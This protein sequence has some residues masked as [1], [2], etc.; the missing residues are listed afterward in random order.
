MQQLDYIILNIYACP[1]GWAAQSVEHAGK[2]WCWREASERKEMQEVKR[3][4]QNRHSE[5]THFPFFW[6]FCPEFISAV[7]PFHTDLFHISF[8][9][10]PFHFTVYTWAFF[11]HQRGTRI[12]KVVN[13]SARCFTV[14]CLRRS[15]P[16]VSGGKSLV[17]SRVAHVV[18]AAICQQSQPRLSAQLTPEFT[19]L[20]LNTEIGLLCI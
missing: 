15:V 11:S 7:K 8:Q 19:F 10:L 13:N 16:F 3:G 5:K 17:M 12:R 1:Q 14:S 2:R 6:N 4:R 18:Y 20:F 9:K